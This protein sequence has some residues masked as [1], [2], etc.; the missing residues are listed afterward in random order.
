MSKIRAAVIAFGLLTA[1]PIS[2]L[3]APPKPETAKS[4]A[5]AA[6]AK[7]RVVVTTDPELDD[8]NSLIRYLLYSTDFRTEGLIYAS[9]QFHWAG[10]GKGARWFVPHREY[11]R[12]G[13]NLCPCASYRW[14]KGERYIDQ[15]VEAYEKAYP[16]LRVH[17][18]DYPPPAELKSK[19]RVGNIDFDGEMIH[20]SPGSDL[21]KSLLLDDDPAPVYLLAWGGHSTIARALRSIQEEYQRGPR[22]H[23]IRQKVIH[24]AVLY[25]SGDQDGTLADYIRPNWPEIVVHE[26]AGGLPLF[27]NADAY[28]TP[29]EGVY[30]SADWT[31]RNVSSRG[32]LGADYRVWGDG[33]QMVKGDIFDYFGLS[34]LGADELRKQG[35]VVWSPIHRKDSFVGE[36]DTGT[37]LNLVDNGLHGYRPETYGGWGGYARPPQPPGAAEVGGGGF[38]V[39]AP[40]RPTKPSLFLAAAQQD[41]A[42]RLKWAVTP[43]YSGA[44]HEPRIGAVGP[45]VLAVRPGR[46]VRLRVAV[47]DPDHDQV[48]VKW[49]PWMQAG[50]YVGAVQVKG[51]KAA[52]EVAVPAD[53]KRGQTIHVIAEATDN[54]APALT[55]YEHFVL[56]VR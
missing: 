18:P 48:T 49:W 31:R 19:I 27:Y 41:F 25:P 13:L 29:E 56:K 35:Y 16:N 39:G 10:D 5:A 12:P 1:S 54:G 6:M 42:A 28:V 9:S 30:F 22:W 50:S 20:D 52:G 44:N 3:A 32:P 45:R 53:A 36:G 33:K 40:K 14:A 23:A 4:H 46:T 37:F 24:K 34:E 47:S 43:D 7:P 26:D 51:E 38:S 8:N 55:H 21:I 17:D 11:D 15:A 2:V